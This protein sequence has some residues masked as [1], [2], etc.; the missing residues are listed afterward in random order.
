MTPEQS[1]EQN[2]EGLRFERRGSEKAKVSLGEA[3]LLVVVAAISD[4]LE[5]IPVFGFV[6]GLA[7]SGAILLWSVF[8]GIHGRF[9]AKKIVTLLISFLADSLT[10]GI[11]PIRTLSLVITIWLNNHVEEKNL[12]RI[13]KI[14]GKA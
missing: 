7:A 3:V 10:G 13:S 5:P 1:P 6:V 14:L 9:F 12:V 8:R 11:F 2:E 4:L